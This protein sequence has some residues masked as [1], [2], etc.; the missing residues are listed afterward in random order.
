LARAQA[1]QRLA[2]SD[3]E[4]EKKAAWLQNE[5]HGTVLG[6]RFIV[7]LCNLAG[8][9]AARAFLYILM[10]YYTAFARKGRAASRAW[11]SHVFKRP[12]T[13]REVY[14]HL[15]TFGL[16]T[17]DRVFLLQ[18]RRELFE[19]EAHGTENL[20][21]LTQQKRGALLLGAHMGSFE[22]M[23]ARAGGRGHD[24]HVLAYL[25]NAR[26][27][28]QVFAALAPEMQARVITLGQVDALIRAKEVIDNGAMVA[29]LG[30]RTGL[31]GKTIQVEFL[32]KPA[33]FPSGPFLLAA[34]LRCPVLLVF[35][36][37]LGKNRYQLHCEPFA[38]RIELPRGKRE[39][40]LQTYVQR[41]AA[42]LAELAEK[43]PYNWFNVYDFWNP[44]ASSP[45]TAT[46]D[47]PLPSNG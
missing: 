42:R 17:L 18:G 20:D 14:R 5:E 47:S 36:I 27:I 37:Y 10:A 28:T 25:D 31:N 6:I 19:L 26:K 40:A 8:R 43:H 2:M 30:D 21:A 46:P 23:R 13:L 44:E 3:Q 15:S 24:I 39:E 45:Q 16:V 34:A 29:M 7:A 12:A 33:P 9:P 41:Y 35:G 22:A 32:G 38:E 11:L 1:R 4:A